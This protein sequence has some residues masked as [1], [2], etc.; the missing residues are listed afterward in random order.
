MATKAGVWIDHKQAVVVLITD[1]GQEIKKIKSGVGAPARSAGGVRPTNKFTA[2]DF[3][4]RAKDRA[5]RKPVSR[6]ADF[7]D[8]VIARLRGAEAILVFG[9]GTAKSEFIRRINSK[10]L[11]GVV[12]VETADKM[13]DR[14]IAAKVSEH[15]ATA[16]ANTSASLK[17]NAGNA[18]SPPSTKRSAK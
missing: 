8:E 16:S 12:E 4:A 14:E 2:H 6:A 15:F 9:P 18:M 3:G 10:K 5:E 7:Y 13:T 11:G 1:A 17:I